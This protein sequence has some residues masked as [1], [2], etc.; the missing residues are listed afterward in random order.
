MKKREKNKPKLLIIVLFQNLID[1]KPYYAKNPAPPLPG[2]LLAALTP[3]QVEVDVLHEMVRPINYNTNADFIAISFMDYLSTH[4]YEVAAKFRAKGKIVIGGG[5]FASTF[6]EEVEPYFDSICVG[7]AHKIWAEM[8]NDLLAGKLKKRY[9]ADLAPDLNDIPAPRYDLVE[10]KYFTPIVTE[11]SR[12]C[13]H[14]CTYCQLNIKRAPYRMRPVEDVIRDLK[15]T[16]GLSWIK[17]KTAM[18]LD[19]NLGGN[20]SNA[21]NLLREISKLNFW[22]IGA[23]YSLE[24]LRDNEFVELLAKANCR[25]S[26]IGM[27]S[28]NEDS[29]L[30]VDKKQNKVEEY[31]EFFYKLNKKGVLTF[32][33]FMFALDED[34]PEY[35]D[36]LPQKL[37]EI[38]VNV[39]LP[40][41]SIPI[42]GT[43]LYKKMVEENRIVDTDISHYEGDHVLFKHKHLSEEQIYYYY[44]KVIKIFYSWNNILKRWWRFVSMQT[45]GGSIKEYLLKTVLGSVIYFKLSIFQRHHAQERV[46]DKQRVKSQKKIEVKAA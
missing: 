46:F 10:S 28:L 24:C 5:K 40:S 39:I 42:Y 34:T 43:P 36:T 35:Y 32:T 18:I 1:E 45:F 16:K 11:A 17:R 23:Q 3:P 37:E 13:P 29:L 9:D 15:N 2:I 21:K 14:P 12:G 4:A 8:V 27:E 6:P 25:M 44:E 41:I 31:K 22:A 33:G 26:F 30:D 38:G 19:N 20:I 7:E